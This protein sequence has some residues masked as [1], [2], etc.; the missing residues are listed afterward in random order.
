MD[1]KK[2]FGKDI[3]ERYNTYWIDKHGKAPNKLFHLCYYFRK[4]ITAEHKNL[5]VKRVSARRMESLANEII[6]LNF[7]E[8]EYNDKL[9]AGIL[10]ARLVRAK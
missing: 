9:E 5:L 10:M 7:L 8:K 1:M 2:I 6:K 3:W 4:Y